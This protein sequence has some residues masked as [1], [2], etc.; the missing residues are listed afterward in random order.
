M[1]EEYADVWKT[2][3]MIAKNVV[4]KHTQYP[5]TEHNERALSLQRMVRD[6][7]SEVAIFKLR[8]NG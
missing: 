5:V 2:E 1:T 8:P 3:F 7:L 4:R 6:S